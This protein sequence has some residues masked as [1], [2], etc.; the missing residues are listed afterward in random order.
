MGCMSQNLGVF[1]V[2]LSVQNFQDFCPLSGVG[3]GSY[4]PSVLA[5]GSLTKVGNVQDKA[6]S[7]DLTQIKARKLAEIWRLQRNGRDR[8]GWKTCDIGLRKTLTN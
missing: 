7:R 3:A 6:V 4:T 2:P 5:V 8:V 1:H